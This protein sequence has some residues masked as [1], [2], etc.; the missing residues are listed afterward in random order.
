MRPSAGVIGWTWFLKFLLL[1]WG[2]LIML[3]ILQVLSNFFVEIIW[4]YYLFG[5]FVQ[6]IFCQTMPSLLGEGCFIMYQPNRS[7]SWFGYCF[8]PKENSTTEDIT[9]NCSPLYLFFSYEYSASERFAI[10]FLATLSMRSVIFGNDK[11]IFIPATQRSCGGILFSLHM[12]VRLSVCPSRIRCLLCS[13][14]SSGWIHFIFIHLI[15]QLQ[16]MFCVSSFLQNFKI[17]I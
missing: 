7:N 3:R 4:S 8:L 9:T 10:A 2:I 13:A 17:L 5:I 14:C 1:F 11:G 6:I 16:K 12:F 15:K